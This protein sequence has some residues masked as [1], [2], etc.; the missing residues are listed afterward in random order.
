MI[1]ERNPYPP[2]EF[3]LSRKAFEK[4]EGNL[5]LSA[6]TISTFESEAGT[7]SRFLVFDENDHRKLKYIREY[8]NRLQQSES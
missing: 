8:F 2:P 5:C 1:C 4:I 6:L 7:Y 3:P